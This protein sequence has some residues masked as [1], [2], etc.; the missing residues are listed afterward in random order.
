MNTPDPNLPQQADGLSLYESLVNHIDAPVE[1]I[2]H[3]VNQL[4]EQDTSGQFCASAAR[5][6]SAVDKENFHAPIDSLLKATISKDRE[7]AYLPDLLPAIWGA[8]YQMNADS[9][10]DSDDN[11]RRI[12]K[13]VHPSGII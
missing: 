12:Y 5:F 9:L 4:I 7:L 2:Q 10:R 8:D 11:F 13:R 6:L 1:E 3:A